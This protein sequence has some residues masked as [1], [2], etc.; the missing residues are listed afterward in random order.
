MEISWNYE[1]WGEVFTYESIDDFIA[2]GTLRDG[3][4]RVP[5][6]A[7]HPLEFLI[8]GSDDI[9]DSTQR[10]P[11]FFSGALAS[12]KG[13]SGP[14]F[15]GKK[16]AARLNTGF[17]AFSDPLFTEDGDIG[18]AW[19]TGSAHSSAQAIIAR[20][21]AHLQ[22]VIGRPL[23]FVG[24]SGGGFAALNLNSVVAGSRAFV[25]NPQTNILDYAPDAVKRYLG[26]AIGEALPVDP[27]WRSRAEEELTDAGISY[28]LSSRRTPQSFFYLQ[29]YNDWHVQ[30]HLARFLDAHNLPHRGR[31]YY[32]SSQQG[33]LVGVFGEGHAVP[34]SE[35]LD[36]ALQR[37]LES[38]ATS[39][40]LLTEL[41]DRK[42]LSQ[43]SFRQLPSD[44]R[45]IAQEIL[46]AS[47]ISLTQGAAGSDPE[48][49]VTLSA[50]A[51]GAH[52]VQFSV[53]NGNE[54]LLVSLLQFDQSWVA[55]GM[56]ELDWDEVRC[57]IFDGFG[58]HLGHCTLMQK[59]THATDSQAKEI[60]PV[61]DL[62]R[63]ALFPTADK[64][65]CGK[66][67]IY[68]SSVSRDAFAL[69][70]APTL[71]GYFA[72]STVAS[73]MNEKAHD[74]GSESLE[75]NPSKFQQRMV[76]A[77]LEK[78]LRDELIRDNFDYLLVDFID[79]RFNVGI[80][81]DGRIH[82]ISPELERCEL[83]LP[84]ERVVGFGSAEHLQ[85]FEAGWKKLTALVPAQKIVINKVFWAETDEEGQP[86]D[87]LSAIHKANESMTRLYEIVERVS[88]N[89]RWLNYDPDILRSN[90]Q[91]KWGVSPFHYSDRFYSNTV[92]K[93]RRF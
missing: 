1:P 54:R 70:D 68:G 92:I 49:S 27:G 13:S 53:W 67:L 23:V 7:G 11:V 66:F 2:I 91:H 71:A 80:D 33:V 60:E 44:E 12:R 79:E 59:D 14:Y 52:S 24:G 82:T 28:E 22:Q 85:N 77:D 39:W 17:I 6:Q 87:N 86:L 48:L 29:N 25:W 9:A 21:C 50:R 43:A 81:S 8:S 40:D 73:A 45:P 34:S 74:I 46:D 35:L 30:K 47:T 58:H 42:F 89:V 78:T 16:M 3:V 72:R 4:H 88:P 76:F 26:V 51:Q 41:S 38:D 55:K 10:V 90:L 65:D 20:I 93:L 15:S 61:G 75:K 19:Y 84:S 31:G 56:G 63:P 62:N 5:L 69:P 18:L 36:A 83:D 37:Y 57:A 32:G 64:D